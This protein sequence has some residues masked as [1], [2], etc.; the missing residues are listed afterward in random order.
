MATRLLAYDP[1]PEGRSLIQAAA[2]TLGPEYSL[3]SPG[4]LEDCLSQLRRGEIEG[5][6]I[7]LPVGA[8]EMAVLMTACPSPE[9]SPAVFLIGAGDRTM[10]E[11]AG[12]LACVRKD[13]QGLRQLMLVLPSTLRARGLERL[14]GSL[15]RL[16]LQ[17]RAADPEAE[18]ARLVVAE[19]SRLGLRSLFVL[20]D[21]H[22]HR[23]SVPAGSYPEDVLAGLAGM[24]A[25]RP[26]PTRRGRT[27]QGYSVQEVDGGSLI[28]TE[29]PLEWVRRDLQVDGKGAARLVRLL[30]LQAAAVVRV[31]DAGAVR[32][33]LLVTERLSDLEQ[34]ALGG[35]ARPLSSAL[36]QAGALHQLGRQASA[37]R[38]LQ[39]ISLILQATLDPEELVDQALEL[40]ATVVPFDTACVMLGDGGEL[41]VRAARGYEQY[42]D[43]PARGISLPLDDYPSLDRLWTTGRPFLLSNT[44]NH[45]EWVPSKISAHVR[46]WL[47]IPIQRR[48]EMIGAF[49]LDSVTPGFFQDYHVEIAEAFARQ[50][51]VALDNADLL[52]RERE[53]SRRNRLLQELAEVVNA[54]ADVEQIL[55]HLTRLAAEA[56]GVARSGV[57]LLSDDAERLEAMSVHDPGGTIAAH[58]ET[59]RA[60]L[61]GLLRFWKQRS[62]DRAWVLQGADLDALGEGVETFDLKSVLV[63]PIRREGTLLGLLAL[64][65]PGVA[66]GFSQADLALAMA[67]ADHGAVA[68]R[69]ALAFSEIKRRT[70]E[71]ASLLDLG[72]ALSQ[73]TTPE[74]VVDLLL[75]HVGRLVQVDSAVVARLTSPD[76]LYCDVLDAGRRLPAL[77]V[78]LRGPTLSGHVIT[79][80]KPLLIHDYDA[81]ASSLPVPGLMTGIPTASWLGVPLIA[82]G[83]TIGAV[84]VQSEEPYRFTE[85]HL[86]LLRM[87]ANQIAVALDNAR[88]LQ[89]AAHRADELRLVNEIGRYAVSVLDIQQ[90]AREVA[91]RILNAF[92]YYSVQLM[93]IE[94]GRLRPAAVVRSPGAE[95]VPTRRTLS[96]HESTIMTTVA[97]SGRAWLVPDVK[98]EPRYQ[99]IPEL[100]KTRSE[101]A[102]PLVIAR[103]VVGVLDVQSDQPGGLSDADLELLQVLAAQVAISIAN[104][105]LFAEVRAHA[106]QLEARV[107]ARTAEIRSQKE[108]TEAILRSVADAVVVLDL[109]GQLVMANPVAQALLEGEKAGD[110]LSQISRLH[111]QGGVV[112]ETVELGEAS[113]QALASPVTLGDLAVGT[114]IVLRDI[115]RL[116]ELDRL[117]SHFVATVSHELRT[118][119]ANIKLYL[120]LL[121][122]GREDRRGQYLQVLEKETARLGEMIEDLLDLSRLE[123]R[124]AREERESVELGP[125]LA[126]VVENHRPAFQAKGL[127]VEVEAA[128]EV[129]VIANRNQ[130][131][132]I[133]T[134]LLSNAL[135]YTPTGG[136]VRVA[137][138]S[139]QQVGDQ[140]M[141]C[142]AVQDSGQGIPE[143]DLPY[144]FERFYRGSLA[145]SSKIPGSGLGL[146]IVREILERHG[147]EVRVKSRLGEGSTFTVLLPLHEEA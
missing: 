10:L 101:L 146:A 62:P 117:K 125:L 30:E 137:L 147:G 49:S 34:S 9:S 143:E 67:L 70:D 85:D 1:D 86:R 133:F 41:R 112:S 2:R 66:R 127:K 69:N 21:P 29:D 22:T 102:V 139:P 47:G 71:L 88:L 126:Q 17:A 145:R 105:R 130:L 31:S 140:R 135:H 79:S 120:S 16:S 6:L 52:D 42:A 72:I 60:A 11:E 123:S 73:A 43:I 61:L 77:S 142:I 89:T 134:N 56:L 118:P 18:L 138:Q 95:L 124:A 81:E 83:E 141:A 128:T 57:A 32:A 129:V 90:L 39:Q 80:G 93:L 45:P 131:I 107:T 28:Y 3:E 110:V 51:G 13:D 98:D 92:R 64:D 15:E 121:R 109:D 55:D 50:V 113:F 58:R 104:A 35:L 38:A 33:V 82:R 4:R 122:K 94:D 54:A 65:D 46:S 97:R 99:H 40:L 44:E 59:A 132:R 111:S 5:L 20:I 36:S 75:G 136:W 87:V 14:S 96:L 100:P 48:G 68:L 27:R 26:T 108:R 37:L 53:A 115:S 63:A 84:S 23:L 8:D 114:V 103:E 25:A 91:T 119:L 19:L 106:A 116:R 78:P 12:W 144:I 7:G 24:L 76:S 74:G